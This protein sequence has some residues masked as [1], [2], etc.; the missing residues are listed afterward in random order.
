MSK[1]LDIMDLRFTL[2]WLKVFIFVLASVSASLA[3]ISIS[4]AY[5]ETSLDNNRPAGQ[6]IVT[7]LGENE[8]RF[9]IQ[10]TYFS[11]S[12]EGV[13][14]RIPP[15]EHSLTGWIKFNPTEFNVP[16]KSKRSIRYVIVPQG[17]LQTGEY[18]GAMELESLQT[19]TTTAKDDS[20]HEIK[21]EVIAS[22]MVPIWG[23]VGNVRY[24]GILKEATLTPSEKGAT[25]RLLLQNTGEGRLLIG[26]GEF[27]IRNRSGIEIERGAIGGF[28]LLPGQELITS[29]LLKSSME[30]GDYQIQITCHSPQLKAP[31]ENE[32]PLAWK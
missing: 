10:A 13:L 29:K 11:F 6:F 5:I 2:F 22:I 4:P 9:R 19:Q 25:L 30:P 32:F 27:V 8:E 1:E 28:I 20:G 31:L 17:S 18:W 23:K 16:A 14:Q 12:R 24:Q 7:N 21:L 3:G 26:Q 15:D